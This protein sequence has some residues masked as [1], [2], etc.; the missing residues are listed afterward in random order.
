MDQSATIAGKKNQ[1]SNRVPRVDHLGR[2]VDVTLNFESKQQVK[3]NPISTFPTYQNIK[4][5]VL[6]RDMRILI[7]VCES[8]IVKVFDLYMKNEVG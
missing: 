7:T 5:A 8:S 2:K 1:C 4:R 3:I 6:L